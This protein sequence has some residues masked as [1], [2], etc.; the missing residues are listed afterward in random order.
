MR[1][2][3]LVL[4][5][6]GAGL[7]GVGLPRVD[8]TRHARSIDNAL[9]F[10][11][12]GR[13]VELA[14]TGQEEAIA[15]LLWAR[16]VLTF[17]ERWG[18]D[19]SAE[20]VEWMYRMVLVVTELDPGWRTPY[21]Y[22]SALMRVLGDVDASDEILSRGHAALPED[23]FFPFS[24]GMNCY[25][26][27][28]DAACAARWYEIAASKPGAARWIAGA[29]AKMREDA[30][31]RS[32]AIA[33]LENVLRSNPSPEVRTDSQWQLDRLRHNDIVDAWAPACRA[34]AAQN[35]RPPRSV[36]ELE[37]YAGAPMPPNPRGDAW[38]IGHDGLVRSAAA[39]GE[40]VRRLRKAEWKLAGP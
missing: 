15:D 14:A 22:G 4:L 38:V 39:E 28:D 16:A 40:R 17:G 5:L 37:L 23:P 2:L 13:E 32:A 7:V 35:G 10:L 18:K 6:A 30:G 9:L 20:W 3:A 21:F 1:S 34:F 11:P 24:M 25:V 27:R 29:A 26:Y 12:N 8:H 33:Y 31:D 36:A 19:Q